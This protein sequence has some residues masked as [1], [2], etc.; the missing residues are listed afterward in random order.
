MSKKQILLDIAA[1][2]DSGPSLMLS[3][4]DRDGQ[5][6]VLE[7]FL[8]VCYNERGTAPR[9]LDG[10]GIRTVLTARLPR[11]FKAK[12]AVAKLAPDVIGAFLEHLTG[13]ES[14]PFAFEMRLGLQDAEP[15]YLEALAKGP[16]GVLATGRKPDPFKHGAVKLGR[17]D[18]CSC[19]SG[20]KYKKCHGKKHGA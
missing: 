10:D 3:A 19:G 17:N 12:D 2:L 1:F 7:A 20:K 14:V 5:R 15:A 18:P 6:K 8:E 16:E 13:I 4:P 11:H 9:F